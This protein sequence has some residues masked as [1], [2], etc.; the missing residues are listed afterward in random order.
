VSFRRPYDAEAFFHRQQAGGK[1]LAAC[2]PPQQVQAVP[3]GVRARARGLAGQIFTLEGRRR[4]NL[5]RFNGASGGGI[6]VD[7]RP[8]GPALG[9]SRC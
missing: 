5:R 6:A 3:A 4:C 9:C 7:V 8:C 2:A 1:G